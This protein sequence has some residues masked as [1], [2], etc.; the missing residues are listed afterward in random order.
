MK[1]STNNR[2]MVCMMTNSTCYKESYKMK[3][4]GV[5]WHSTGANNPALSR[6]VQP[7]KDDK[8]YDKL[9][10]LLG[11]NKY[12]NS[13]NEITHYAGVNAWIG[14]LKDGSVTTV[15][16]LPWD[17]RP[18]GCGKGKNGSC[19]S[20][21]IQFEIC[22]DALTDKKYFNQVY[23]E[24]CELTAFLCKEYDID[25]FGTVTMNSVKIPTILCHA[26]SYKLGMGNNHG[27]VLYWFTKYG[28]TMN[29]VR[30]DV[31]A[32]LK[33]ATHYMVRVT[34][35]KLNIRSGPGTS[36]KKVGSITDRG[37][38]TIIQVKNNWG[39]LKSQ[40]VYISLS[41]TEKFNQ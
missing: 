10:D 32:L 24:A 18:W 38:Y 37:I 34:T 15:Q 4:K 8:N 13:W 12:S 30:K 5:L 7:S 3:V 33:Q 14:K 41:Y 19:N 20:G 22:E 27:D 1:Y 25:P 11:K 39:L 36:Y 2:P 9:M 6:Y 35:D 29:D 31:A 23:K 21:W 17:M 26:D 16:T 28:K 40:S